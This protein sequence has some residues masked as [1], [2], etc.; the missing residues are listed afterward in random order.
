MKTP[1]RTATATAN[2]RIVKHCLEIG[3]KEVP[4]QE[5]AKTGTVVLS[6]DKENKPPYLLDLQTGI[7]YEMP[8]DQLYDA[9]FYGIHASPDGNHLA[10]VDRVLNKNNELVRDVVWVVN[11]RGEVEARWI[12]PIDILNSTWHW[13]DNERLELNVHQ[14]Q[15]DGTV[16]IFYPFSKKWENVYNELPDLLIDPYYDLHYHWWLVDYNPN[17]KWVVYISSSKDHWGPTLWDITTQK[18][19]WKTDDMRAEWD[20]PRWSPSGNEL[21][22][23][24][25]GEMN[26]IDRSGLVTQIPKLVPRSEI[27]EF[28]W[29]PD[30]QYMALLVSSNEEDKPGYLMV[31]DVRSNQ[32]IDYCLESYNITWVYPPIW[33]ADS[34]QFV[35]GLHEE[36]APFFVEIKE[37]FAVRL[38]DDSFPFVWMNSI[39]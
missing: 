33:S 29:S 25:N 23:I 39:P 4:M 28:S 21:A 27:I 20:I 6:G 32:I 36:W 22:A 13:L 35:Y 9:G 38:L 8:F 30:G 3:D 12:L 11:A 1:K 2:P 19:I 37:E 24:S 5:V 17:L 16:D 34:Q 31:Y 10:Y 15:I 14:T 7:R 26:I 18:Q